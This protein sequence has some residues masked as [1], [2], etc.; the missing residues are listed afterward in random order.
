MIFTLIKNV[1]GLVASPL[2]LWLKTFSI[3]VTH[4]ILFSYTVYARFSCF[5][6]TFYMLLDQLMLSLFFEIIITSYDFAEIEIGN[7]L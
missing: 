2:L 3:S 7:L 5:K 6:S 4:A 1:Y